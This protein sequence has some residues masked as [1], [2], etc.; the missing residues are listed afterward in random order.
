M[1]LDEAAHPQF[2]ILNPIFPIPIRLK[3]T[4]GAPPCRCCSARSLL[5]YVSLFFR[6]PAGG[7]HREF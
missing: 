2:Y 3:F 6:H 5:S 1:L 7:E 4:P